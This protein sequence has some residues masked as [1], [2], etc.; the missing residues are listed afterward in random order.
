L[1]SYGSQLGGRSGGTI[2]RRV[3][4]GLPASDVCSTRG[5][6]ILPSN[7]ES[8]RQREV[9]SNCWEN[10]ASSPAAFIHCAAATVRRRRPA[11]PARR[12]QAPA[13]PPRRLL[14]YEEPRQRSRVAPRPGP[15]SPMRGP[16]DLLPGTGRSAANLSEASMTRRQELIRW[17]EE[18]MARRVRRNGRVHDRRRSRSDPHQRTRDRDRE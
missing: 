14:F 15:A 8:S 3:V 10:A 13:T 1:L 7:T 16:T 12:G 5:I 11:F 9:S 6:A 2:S 17:S 4:A 18:A